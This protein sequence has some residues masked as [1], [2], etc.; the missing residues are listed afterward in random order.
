MADTAGVV[1]WCYVGHY[2]IIVQL[3]V[4]AAKQFGISGFAGAKYNTRL[5]KMLCLS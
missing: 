3:I 4:L 1:D 2:A 5:L